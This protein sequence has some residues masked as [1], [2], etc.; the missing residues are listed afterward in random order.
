MGE[1]EG[2]ELARLH[3]HLAMARPAPQE[4]S[5]HCFLLDSTFG[6]W[7]VMGR[8][9]CQAVRPRSG[10]AANTEVRKPGQVH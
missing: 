10:Y 3:S 2:S 8:R 5:Q 7:D 1:K 9:G 4:L 6:V